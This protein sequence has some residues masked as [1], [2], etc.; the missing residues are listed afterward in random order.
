MISERKKKYFDKE[1]KKLTADGAHRTAW[2]ALHNLFDAESSAAWTLETLDPG[3]PVQEIAEQLADHFA[4]IANEYDPVSTEGAPETYQRPT[5]HLTKT[6]V[7]ARLKSIKKPNSSVSIDPLP[8]HIDVYIEPLAAPLTTILN[9]VLQGRGWPRVWKNEEVTVIPK[10]GNA[11]TMD[12]CRNITCTSIFSKL[13]ES[14]MLDDLNNEIPLDANQFGGVK[15]IGTEHMIT[16]MT[17]DLMEC[18]EDPRV[19]VTFVSGDLSKAFN[20]VCPNRCLAA[21]AAHGASINAIRVVSSFLD[22]RIMRSR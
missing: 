10:G 2:K 13:A 22:G 17:T 16:E 6:E 1:T 18:L 11:V 7:A 9:D 4:A 20:R 21:L 15:G 3:R 12:Q 8:K 14:F 19:A 5:R